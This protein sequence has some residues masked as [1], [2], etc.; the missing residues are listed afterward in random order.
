MIIESVSEQAWIHFISAS[1]RS[2]FMWL[3]AARFAVLSLFI[4]S[5]VQTACGGFARVISVITLQL[6]FLLFVIIQREYWHHPP[7]II[8]V[9][10]TALSLEIRA[11]F[12]QQ[13]VEFRTK[14]LG[15]TWS[16]LDLTNQWIDIAM[17]EVWKIVYNNKSLVLKLKLVYYV[18]NKCI[19]C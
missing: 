14:K 8:R 9:S 10:V 13:C 16:K 2:S 7:I 1:G 3:C 18:C 6:E 15:S 19:K 12:I 11:R 17:Y 5:N 4:Y